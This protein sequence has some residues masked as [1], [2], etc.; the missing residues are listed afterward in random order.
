MHEE[1]IPERAEWPDGVLE[2]VAALRQGDVVA[3]L[4]IFWWASPLRPV[5]ARTRHYATQG[6]TDDGVVEL[7]PAPYGMVTTQ[8]CDLAQEG[9]G[10]PKSAWVQLAPVFNAKSAHP[11]DPERRLL[12]GGAR[13]LLSAG[14]DQF[15]LWI[16]DIPEPGLWFA[17]LTFEVP[18]E[19][20]WLA[21]LPRIEG[22][23]DEGRRE[24]VGRRLAWLRSRPAFDTRFAEAVQRPT[25]DAL[26]GLGRT[27]NDAYDRMHSQVVEVGV[28]TDGRLSVG[29]AE[30]VV[31]HTGIDDDVS[32]WWR[33]LWVELSG[34]AEAKGFNLLPLRFADLRE[35]PASEYREMTRLP[36]AAISD[37]PAWYGSDPQGFPPEDA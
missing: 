29:H 27:D 17:D 12:D 7:G 19:R 35:L 11:V 15:R 6:I 30:L 23:R 20:G 14:R 22:F 8:T 37:N 1:G 13:K 4:P 2:A 33:Q 24:E 16:P 3:S 34:N 18:V 28:L 26:R 36:L 21:S 10:K 32:Q 25:I 9:A 5:H 31:L